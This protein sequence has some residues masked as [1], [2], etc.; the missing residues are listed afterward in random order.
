[1]KKARKFL[2]KKSRALCFGLSDPDVDGSGVYFSTPGIEGK[3]FFLR[4]TGKVIG[5]LAGR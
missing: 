3:S 2:L 5:L 4:K 1:M